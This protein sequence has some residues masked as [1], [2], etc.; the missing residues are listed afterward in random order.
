MRR[1][2]KNVL[3]QQLGYGEGD[4][5]EAED[6]MDA[7]KKLKDN[8]FKMDLIL[9][10]WNMPKMDGITFVRKMQTVDALKKIPI[11]MVT[12]EAEKSKIIEA[13]K[14]GAKNY[15]VKPFTPDLLKEKIA[16]TLG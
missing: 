12:T 5:V 14:A 8:G 1:I 2:Q 3:I 10:D 4:V 11:I 9:C 13:I 6:G 16:T 7:F 15:L